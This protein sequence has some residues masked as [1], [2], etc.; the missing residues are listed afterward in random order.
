MAGKLLVI[1]P[2]KNIVINS[3]ALKNKDYFH[4]LPI[5][6]DNEEELTVGRLEKWAEQLKNEIINDF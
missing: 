2:E 1:G 4:G 5:D 6:Q 3:K